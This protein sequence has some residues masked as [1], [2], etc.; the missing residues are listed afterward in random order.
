MS[1]SVKIFRDLQDDKVLE[2]E[3]N[4]GNRGTESADGSTTK[5]IFNLA[6]FNKYIIGDAQRHGIDLPGTF[7]HVDDLK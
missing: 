1:L 7:V 3:R 5:C 2:D 4:G 6:F